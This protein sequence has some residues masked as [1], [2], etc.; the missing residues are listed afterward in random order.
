ML[1]KT[2]L[3]DGVCLTIRAGPRSRG[4]DDYFVEI[5]LEKWL[6]NFCSRTGTV[7]I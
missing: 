3:R 7:M 1:T 5:E 4:V 2:I 6:E